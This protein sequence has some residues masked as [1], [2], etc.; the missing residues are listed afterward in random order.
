MI[1]R[2]VQLAILSFVAQTALVASVPEK[3][4]TTM[5]LE[6]WVL[7]ALAG[8]LLLHLTRN[9]LPLT[10]D[11]LARPVKP[12]APAGRAVRGGDARNRVRSR[13][14]RRPSG[15]VAALRSSSATRCNRQAHPC[16][17]RGAALDAR[18][19]V[20]A[21]RRAGGLVTDAVLTSTL[22]AAHAVLDEVERAVVGK[23]DVLELVLM[24]FLADGHVLL[25][26]LPG[27]AKTLMARSFAAATGLSFRRIQFT[28]DLLPS[29]ITGATL[30]DQRT[31]TFSFRP[32]PLFANLVL[33]DEVNRAPAKTQA[34][35][36]EAMQERQVTADG[37]TYPLEPPFL[38]VATQNPIEY[39][40]TYP[41]PE[42]QL[43]RFILRTAVGYPSLDDEWN[44]LARRMERG[45]D[46]VM[47]T[48][49]T[50]AAGLRAMQ[51]SLEC[52][53]VDEAIGRYVVALVDAT[54]N[55]AAAGRGEP[56]WKPRPDQA[57]SCPRAHRG[58]RLRHTR[59]REGDPGPGARASRCVAQRPVGATG[60]CCGRA[61][62]ARRRGPGAV[63]RVTE[64]IALQRR[65]SPRLVA[66]A[67]VAVGGL[68]GGLLA[69]RP[70]LV[71]VAA[72]FALIFVAGVVL[73]E[74]PV[75]SV[76]IRAESDRVVAGEDIVVAI[77]VTS[78]VPASRVAL[79]LPHQGFASVV[80]PEDRQLSWAVRV[81][82]S[83]V[84]TARLHTPRWGVE[85]LGPARLDVSGPLGLVRWVGR[86]QSTSIVRVLPDDGTLQTLLPNLEPR[87]ASGAHVAR[88]RG[89]G[90]EFAEI[91]QYREGDRLRSVNWYQT[92]RRGELWVNDHH[93]ERSGD[94]VVVVD[95]FADR[96]PDGSASLEDTVRAAWQ[97]AMAHLAAHDRVG[98]VAFGGLPAWV[99][100][101]GGERARLAVLDRLLDSSAT[102]NE[103]QR[104]VSFLPRQIFPAGAQVI[105]VSGLHDERMTSAIA[106]LARRGHD[107]SVVVIEER[108]V[109]GPEVA[110]NIV[111]ARRLW[112]LELRERRRAL[113][114][115][116]I[117]VVSMVGNDPAQIFALARAR[118]RPVR[119]SS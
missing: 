27:V 89:D 49:V 111:L 24:G 103:A 92:A 23:R 119:R 83:A 38:V 43:D 53:H 45:T 61:R 32:G 98:I 25:D 40:G 77:T 34:A 56:A 87:T 9:R 2:L 93:P 20:G 78:T 11:P 76:D 112:R 64:R 65:A 54:R 105:A 8:A 50:D 48:A 39:E 21:V 117:P 118:R 33:A 44:L 15:C 3:R 88:R 73:A 91:R 46:E 60:R 18:R 63:G 13:A 35:L 26:D 6:L 81:A 107:T 79:W 41:L 52:V 113:E 19:L 62:R 10:P 104:S 55:G 29:D 94:L 70:E 7:A 82:G 108:E 102:W 86:G 12:E 17:S 31:Q 68:F 100:P 22:R 96:R 47:L 30:L 16:R 75:V 14:H 71:A 109:A 5:R 58:S 42:A 59:R 114:R 95:T 97:I 99:L 1:R 106:D 115:L 69:G 72:P 116:G 36:L 37:I 57:G 4:T 90:F 66:V 74:R 67:A 51:A 84:L 28:P 101:G 110:A 80:E 85:S